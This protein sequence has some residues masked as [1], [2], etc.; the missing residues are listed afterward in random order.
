MELQ[1]WSYMWVGSQEVASLV[2]RS[3]SSLGFGLDLFDDLVSRVRTLA[4]RRNRVA[5]RRRPRSD[6]RCMQLR[7]PSLCFLLFMHA[8]ARP[9]SIA[10]GLNAVLRS[11]SCD[12]DRTRLITDD[13]QLEG[14][15][16][17]AAAATASADALAVCSFLAWPTVVQG[18]PADHSSATGREGYSKTAGHSRR[19]FDRLKRFLHAVDGVLSP[20][21]VLRRTGSMKATHPSR[22]AALVA[23]SLGH[24]LALMR[25]VL[26]AQDSGCFGPRYLRAGRRGL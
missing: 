4:G 17:G 10:N 16:G 18:T 22:T 1:L 12:V 9:P 21:F 24:P 20:A 19:D 6:L 23:L 2:L 26:S 25:G 15:A 8:Y 5:L 13:H 11:R 3:L 14:L 7:A